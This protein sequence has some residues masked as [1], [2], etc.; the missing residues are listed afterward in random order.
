MKEEAKRQEKTKDTMDKLYEKMEE[1]RKK[2][3]IDED[4]RVRE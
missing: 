1:T 3:I 4:E 2:V